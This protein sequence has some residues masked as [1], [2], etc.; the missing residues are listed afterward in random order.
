MIFSIK[1]I[2]TS[3]ITASIGAKFSIG[4][5]ETLGSASIWLCQNGY[6]GVKI[7]LEAITAGNKGDKVH[8]IKRKMQRTT[9]K[10]IIF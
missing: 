5:S 4:S 9:T 6:D 3:L 2:Q 10:D 1:E 8:T 7:A